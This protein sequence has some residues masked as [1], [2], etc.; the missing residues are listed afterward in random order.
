M[1]KTMLCSA[2]CML[3]GSAQADT[4]PPASPQPVAPQP[5]VAPAATPKAPAEINCNY[6]IS[7]DTKNIEQSLVIDWAKKAVVQA[8]DFN[9]DT[10][11]GQ[12][13]ELKNCFT[14]QGWQGFNTALQKSGN[15]DAIKSQKLKVTSQVDGDAKITQAKDNQW[16]LSVPLQV[17]Y[18]NSKEKVTQKLQVNLSVG[19]KVSGD[20]GVD[21]LVA[22]TRK[23]V[24]AS[25]PVQQ[26]QPQTQSTEPST[27]PSD[28][29]AEKP[30]T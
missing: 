10:I 29:D 7:A 16:E 17:V 27:Q 9:P 23:D 2:L 8:F 13:Q 1:K 5:T 26:A 4:N 25:I 30:Q 15:I 28:S 20:L 14:D 22:T 3:I 6:K 12:I 24:T 19:R 21:K 11:D 18:Q